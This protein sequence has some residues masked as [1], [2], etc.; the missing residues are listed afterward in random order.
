ME[1]SRD[2]L[3]QAV[4]SWLFF[5]TTDCSCWVY[6]CER[7]LSQRGNI[8]LFWNYSDVKAPLIWCKWLYVL[9]LN[10]VTFLCTKNPGW[11]LFLG[12]WS[13]VFECHSEVAC[14]VTV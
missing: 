8:Y 11:I 7:E 12:P 9:L 1:L 3:F 2:H 13:P 5:S 6:I 4:L 14:Y 10:N